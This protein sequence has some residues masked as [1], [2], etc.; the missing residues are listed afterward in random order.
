MQ[1]STSIQ[2]DLCVF[3]LLFQKFEKN[4]I[5]TARREENPAGWE[6]RLFFEGGKHGQQRDQGPGG[7]KGQGLRAVQQVRS[8]GDGQQENGRGAAQGGERAQEQLRAGDAHQG[9]RP[10]RRRALA[11]LADMALSLLG[12]SLGLRLLLRYRARRRRFDGVR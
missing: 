2:Y 9:P 1:E 6:R 8:A 12:L 5:I 10:G 3:S 4:E 11:R 7:G